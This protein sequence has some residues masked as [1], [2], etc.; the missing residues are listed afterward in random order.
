MAVHSPTNDQWRHWVDIEAILDSE[1]SDTTLRTRRD[2]WINA[3]V[4]DALATEALA[5]YDRT[6]ALDLEVV[7]LRTAPPQDQP[8]PTPPARHR[9]TRHHRAD[10][11]ETPG[12][13]K[14]MEPHPYIPRIRSRP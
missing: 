9:P 6:L 13:P 11:R 8:P 5:A 4:F 12:V 7:Q 10:H 2:E 3:G 14:P 1:V